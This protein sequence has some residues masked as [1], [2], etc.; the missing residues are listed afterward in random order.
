MHCT[1]SVNEAILTNIRIITKFL[2]FNKE[3]LETNSLQVPCS[4]WQSW[5]AKHFKIQ[6]NSQSETELPLTA[7]GASKCSQISLL[8]PEVS[9]TWWPEFIYR[10]ALRWESVRFAVCA[11][12]DQESCW[13][14]F[15]TPLGT[16]Q[17]GQNPSFF[18]C[19]ILTSMKAKV[20]VWLKGE[21]KDASKTML[22]WERIE[23]L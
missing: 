1:F 19:C 18:R 5:N 9:G 3:N 23:L 15:I 21:R 11:A 13:A 20:Y 17:R 10:S 16:L 8:R 7:K 6:N 12:G 22:C 14:R 2:F 4:G